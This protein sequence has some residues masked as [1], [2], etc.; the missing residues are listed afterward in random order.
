M[1][2][3]LILA[4]MLGLLAHPAA[5]AA[6]ASPPAITPAVQYWTSGQRVGIERAEIQRAGIIPASLTQ[7]RETASAEAAPPPLPASSWLII[8]GLALFAGYSQRRKF[9]RGQ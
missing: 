9:L 7:S 1:L 8:A 3:P 6:P 4:A 2:R 5:M